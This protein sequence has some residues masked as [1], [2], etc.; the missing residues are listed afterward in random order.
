MW[1]SQV[2]VMAPVI[3]STTVPSKL[4]RRISYVPGTS[5]RE[6]IQRFQQGDPEALGELYDRHQESIF[7]FILVRVSDPQTAEDLTGEVFTNVIA[8]LPDT[9]IHNFRA[10]LFRI[11][12]NQVIDHY[13]GK[14]GSA[15]TSLDDAEIRAAD[16]PASTVEQR[17]ML[18]H[19]Q[20]ALA[21]LEA[22]Q[23]DVVILRFL[24]GLSLQ[25]VAETLNKSVS[26]VKALQHRGLDNLR[27]LLAYVAE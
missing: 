11:A 17:L 13:R 27:Q 25:E 3:E 18:E 10:W 5:D 9:P 6:L 23:R 12:R 8:R 26:A 7:K 24:V 1:Y 16:R 19:V 2:R 21:G 15:M 20:H 22:T 4:K 14:E